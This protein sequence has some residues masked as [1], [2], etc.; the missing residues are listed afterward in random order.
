MQKGVQNQR[1]QLLKFISLIKCAGLLKHMFFLK[2]C[3]QVSDTAA[4]WI[5]PVQCVNVVSL[6]AN[7]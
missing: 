7:R 1:Q 4:D 3:F 5:V 2:N 6:V